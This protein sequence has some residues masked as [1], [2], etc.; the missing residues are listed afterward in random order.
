MRALPHPVHKGGLDSHVNAATLMTGVTKT[1][2]PLQ[3][4][5][6]AQRAPLWP[7]E[8]S[9]YTK[10]ALKASSGEILYGRARCKFRS[11]L[12][13]EASPGAVPTRLDHAYAASEYRTQSLEPSATPQAHSR[14]YPEKAANTFVQCCGAVHVMTMARAGRQPCSSSLTSFSK[15]T[16][17]VDA[18]TLVVSF[19]G[20]AGAWQGDARTPD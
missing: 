5:N 15:L 18:N 20:E 6:R 2:E 8:T 11:A 10:T 1:P 17:T 12:D 4:P 13:W 19:Q 9:A 14:S 7:N 16:I 3:T